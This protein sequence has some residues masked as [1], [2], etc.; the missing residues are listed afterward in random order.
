M[1]ASDRVRSKIHA[2][3]AAIRTVEGAMR[4]AEMPNALY[5]MVEALK[6]IANVLDN[7]VTRAGGAAQD[8][9]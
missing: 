2:V 3:E 7:V 6:E 9:L 1:P 5:A 8:Q 4:D